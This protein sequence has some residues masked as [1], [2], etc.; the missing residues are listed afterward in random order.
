MTTDDR[1]KTKTDTIWER[2][3]HIYLP[4]HEMKKE[5]TKL[6]DERGQSFSKFVI[7]MVTNSINYEKENPSMDTRVKLI[8]DNKTLQDKNKELLQKI[9]EQDSHIEMLEQEARSN[10]IEPFL[11]PDF[12]DIRQFSSRLIDLFKKEREVPK[13]ELYQKL[14]INPMDVDTT[15]AIQ[16]QIEILELY[17]LIKDIGGLWRWKA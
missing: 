3:I 11:E 5:W 8:E 2:S 9:R 7:E 6:A 10:V 12:E 17:G 16:R 1:R 13:E 4:T 14:R 15:T